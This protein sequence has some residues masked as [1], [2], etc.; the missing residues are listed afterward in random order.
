MYIETS[1]NNHDD[2]VFASFKRRVIIQIKNITFYY[3][4]FSFLTN[5]SSK[6]KG[7]FRIRLLLEDN[8][9]SKR[10]NIPKNDLYNDTSTGWT[11]LSL[12]I[13]EEI[14]DNK[15]I[16]D[17]ID[18]THADMRFSNIVITQSVNQIK[19]DNEQLHMF[20]YN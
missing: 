16:Y 8:T 1:S 10:Y 6:S 4:R 3:D 17:E 12:N 11:K 7:C 19:I 14:Y 5:V 15:T 2:N 13:T 9:W 18:K 20:K